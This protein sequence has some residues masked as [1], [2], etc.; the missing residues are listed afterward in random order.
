MLKKKRENFT[1]YILRAIIY[2]LKLLLSIQINQYILNDIKQ[3][4][5]FHKQTPSEQYFCSI[6]DLNI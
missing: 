6:G 2:F 1:L 5:T 4:K 3:E